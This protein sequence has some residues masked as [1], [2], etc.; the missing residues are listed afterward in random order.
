MHLQTIC[1]PNCINSLPNNKFL[2]W[3]KLKAFAD[4]KPEN[5]MLNES[6]MNAF[7]DD[8]FSQLCQL[9]TKQQIFRLVQ[10]ESLCR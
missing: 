6:K 1:F 10:I 7:A 8:M 5:K 4:D 3:S 2:D 9:F